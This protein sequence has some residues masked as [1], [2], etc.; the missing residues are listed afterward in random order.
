MNRDLDFRVVGQGR[1]SL[2]E[3]GGSVFRSLFEH[4]KLGAWQQGRSPAKV[5]VCKERKMLSEDLRGGSGAQP[6][7]EVAAA[8][9]SGSGGEEKKK[10]VNHS[11]G[12]HCARMEGGPCFISCLCRRGEISEEAKGIVGWKFGHNHDQFHLNK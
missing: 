10:L 5:A 6:K 12:R 11:E 3:A 4:S 1:R 2:Q 9:Q 8:G 7:G